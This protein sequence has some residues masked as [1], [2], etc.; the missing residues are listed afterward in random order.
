MVLIPP[1]FIPD[2]DNWIIDGICNIVSDIPTVFCYPLLWAI[3]QDLT[4]KP[5]AEV[6]LA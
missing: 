2:F 3:Y 1:I 4:S 6:E 5:D